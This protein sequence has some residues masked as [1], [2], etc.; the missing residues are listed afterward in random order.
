MSGLAAAAQGYA[1]HLVGTRAGIEY[2][3][4][5]YTGDGIT[6]FGSMLLSYVSFVP[7]FGLL[8]AGSYRRGRWNAYGVQCL[9]EKR[10]RP[11]MGVGIS[12]LSAGAGILVANAVNAFYFRPDCDY[13][14]TVVYHAG[15]L[16]G[17]SLALPGLAWTRYSAGFRR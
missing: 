13:C 1:L 4:S 6:S 15:S 12:L 5:S 2:A 16:I 7:A 11:R 3:Q 14:R 17:L 8:A 9:H 10:L